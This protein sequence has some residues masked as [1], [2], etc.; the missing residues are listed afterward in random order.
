M[1]VYIVLT[2]YS[3]LMSFSH[4]LTGVFFLMFFESPFVEI[5]HL[6]AWSLGGWSS[7]LVHEGDGGDEGDERGKVMYLSI[8]LSIYRGIYTVFCEDDGKRRLGLE[9]CIRKE[10]VVLGRGRA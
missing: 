7:K 10:R 1:I 5:Q 3:N 8:Y 4:H 9:G 2:K 6:A